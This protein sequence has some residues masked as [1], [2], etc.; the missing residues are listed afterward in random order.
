[1]WGT[2]DA[3]TVTLSFWVKSS[4]AG[5]YSFSIRT[6][7]AGVSYTAP[8]TIN[9]TNTWEYKTITIPGPTIG[10]WDIG[11]SENFGYLIW[12]LG[13]GSDFD[14]GANNTWT[15]VTNG[16]GRTSH[17]SLLSTLNATWQITGIQLEVGSTA[18]PFEHRPFGTELAL[19]QRYYIQYNGDTGTVSGLGG[20]AESSTTARFVV[21]LP[22]PM[23]T[24]PSVTF[25]GTARLQSGNFDSADFTSI[26]SVQ[27]VQ[28]P[29]VSTTFNA[30]TTGMA[31]NGAGNFQFRANGSKLTF[32][33]EL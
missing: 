21:S 28:Q 2:S 22:V 26:N 11:D 10:T 15:S 19:C 17:V 27:T 3:K 29:F 25:S 18:T 31:A 14:T 7:N 6:P 12:S 13:I 8:Y 16:Q 30:T 5:T 20:Y 32:S 4:V 24:S 1:V 23:R 9:V 33:S